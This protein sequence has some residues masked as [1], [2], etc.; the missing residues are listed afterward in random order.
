MTKTEIV[1]LDKPE[2][3]LAHFGDSFDQYRVGEEVIA[4][5]TQKVDGQFLRVFKNKQFAFW[6]EENNMINNH[7]ML[8]DPNP[9]LTREQYA[10]IMLDVF[11]RV[12]EGDKKG[13]I[14]FRLPPQIGIRYYEETGKIRS[15]GIKE[16][17]TIAT[18]YPV[19]ELNGDITKLTR[20][21]HFQDFHDIGLS[22]SCFSKGLTDLE[23]SL[24]DM[25]FLIGG[26]LIGYGLRSFREGAWDPN[27]D[28]VAVDTGYPV[29][30]NKIWPLIV[31]FYEKTSRFPG[32]LKGDNLIKLLSSS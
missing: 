30:P 18:C 8:W 32:L 29:T 21:P 5:L 31:D 13:D 27:K 25:P 17:K 6:I 1:K 7:E 4:D 19:L 22:F 9:N 28:Y 2:I 24:V 23:N 14:M 3:D 11:Q 26:G 15:D 16:S 10:Q 12:I 20:D